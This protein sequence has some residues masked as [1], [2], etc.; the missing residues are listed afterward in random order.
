MQDCQTRMHLFM[1]IIQCTWRKKSLKTPRKVEVQILAVLDWTSTDDFYLGLNARNG[2][3]VSMFELHSVKLISFRSSN[4]ML[5]VMYP[6]SSEDGFECCR[7]ADVRR[8]CGQH[9]V[10]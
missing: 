8:Y 4:T 3:S 9:L 6:D 10:V 1:A 5:S 7:F 2:K